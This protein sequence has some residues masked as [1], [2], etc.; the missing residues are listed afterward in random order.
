M[1]YKNCTKCGNEYP[2]TI[3]YFRSDK[4][5][6]SGLGAWC[7]ECFMEWQKKRRQTLN[8]YLRH[9]FH[10]IKDR[11]DN[12]NCKSFKDYGG[13]GVKYTFKSSD[14]FINYVINKLQIDPRGLAI[15]RIDNDG[16]YEPRN[17]RFVTQAENNKNR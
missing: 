15:D 6:K 8:G 13:R 1:K 5:N 7:R 17:I 10:H 14:E 12:P 9:V 3:E 2:A 11:C 4:R 16:N